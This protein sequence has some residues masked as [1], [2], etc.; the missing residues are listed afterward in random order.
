M[1]ELIIH[2]FIAGLNTRIKMGQLLSTSFVIN[3]A[4]RHVWYSLKRNKENPQLMK[5]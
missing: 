3:S 2:A 5:T 1:V 4:F